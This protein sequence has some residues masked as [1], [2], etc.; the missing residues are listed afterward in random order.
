MLSSGKATATPS[1]GSL[2]K[3]EVLLSIISL[4]IVIIIIKQVKKDKQ[5][6]TVKMR[7]GDSFL[8]PQVKQNMIIIGDA[9]DNVRSSIWH[10]S[11]KISNFGRIATGVEKVLVSVSEKVSEM[12]SEKNHN[13]FIS[14]SRLTF[15]WNSYIFWVNEIF[16]NS[17]QSFSFGTAS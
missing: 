6:F 15:S 17:S 13:F 14:V 5:E 12:V 16:M 9:L 10:P 11:L 3:A 1:Q 8:M 2:K 7:E 4:F